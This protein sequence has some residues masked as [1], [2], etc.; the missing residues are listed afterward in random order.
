[1][2]QQVFLKYLL[3]AFFFVIGVSNL[4]A[5]DVIVK[6]DGSTIL[7]KTIE[8]TSDVIKYKKASNLDGPTYSIN[9]SEIISVNYENGEKDQFNLI[10]SK[11]EAST[12][13]TGKEIY[14][15]A[16]TEIPIQ[17]VSPVKAADVKVGQSVPFK[18]SKDISVDGVTVIPY[19]TPVKG[20][21]YKAEKSSWWGT[22]GKLGIQIN[23]ITL[24][25]GGIIPLQ[26]GNVYVTGTN[27][28]TLSVLLFLF[29]TIPACA[30]CGSKAAI[31]VGYEV[32]ASVADNVTIN[33]DGT[34]SSTSA[35]TQNSSVGMSLNS[36][37]SEIP[38]K[39]DAR[40]TIIDLYGNET[41]CIVLAMDEEGIL[42]RTVNRKG[43]AGKVDRK[44]K[45][46]FVKEIQYK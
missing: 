5:Q 29:I 32:L 33:A 46:S 34:I 43:V 11:D 28:T 4:Y 41:E 35:L 8:V 44:I 25:N 30:I 27:R 40:A 31:P 9:I 13:K 19:G 1:M 26:N 39:K 15:K 37:G 36:K 12:Q 6:K 42:Y 7:C 20:T 17:I 23:N 38:I 24:P 18:V 14:L 45:K 10:P 21:V 3:C 2:N 22:K 16:G